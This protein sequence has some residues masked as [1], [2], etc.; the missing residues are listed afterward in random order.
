MKDVVVGLIKKE[1]DLDICDIENLV[2]VPP[3]DDMGDFAFPCFGLAKKLKSNPMKI[4][5]DL[6]EKFRR[7]LPKE[8]SNVDFEGPYVNFFIDKKILAKGVLARVKKKGFGELKLD[9]KK[10]GI[11]YP[12]PNTNKALHV[13][14]LRNMAIGEAVTKM[15]NNAG[16]KTFHLNL[17]NDRGILI[18]KSMIGYEKFAKGK[19]PGKIKGDKFVGDLYV[20]FSK[21]S[22]EKPEL[23]EAAKEKLC[24]WE[25]GD[26]ETLTLWKKLNDWAYSGMQETFD[27]FGLSKVDKNYYESEMYTE[28]RSIVE[29][30]LKKGLFKKKDGAV[31]I[32]LEKEKLGEKV[33]LRGDGTTVYMTQDLFLAEKKVEDF[34]LDSSYYVVGSDQEYHF[35][36][37]FSILDKLGLKKDWRHLSYGMVSLP[38]GKMKSREGTAVSA[39]DLIDETAAIAKKG[40]EE[41]ASEKLSDKELKERSLKIALAAIKYTLL[42]VDIHKGIV[43]NPKEALSFEGDTGPYLLYSYA[44]ASSII[45]KV[46]SKAVMKIVDMKEQEI[47]L[48]KKIDSFGDIVRRAYENLAPNLIANYSF[49]LASLFNEFYHACPVLGSIEEGFRL[50]LVDAFRVT[51]KKSLDLLGIEAIEEM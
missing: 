34:D 19:S 7:E 4:A 40:I 21:E 30:G 29:D 15:V 11:E 38:T 44:R 28:G 1:L 49:E 12:S 45:K 25:N 43:F 17:F 37:L 2:E 50:K 39:D 16:N 41:R 20:K 8:V 5:E 42:K 22:A 14:H 35:K 33:L 9:K 3:K 36:V 27:K 32:D 6:A 48:L 18:S 26:K 31:I 23:E 24:L 47:K 10:I 51:L 13:G 46:K